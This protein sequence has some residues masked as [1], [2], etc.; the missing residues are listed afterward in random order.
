MTDNT[1]E[2]T[3]AE[4]QQQT[5]DRII[6]PFLGKRDPLIA[7]LQ[8]TQT[9]FG[10]VPREAIEEISNRLRIPAAQ[11][12]G[13][14]TFYAHF[15]LQRRGDHIVRVCQGTACH[16]R[17]A[18]NIMKTTEHHLGIKTGETTEDYGYTLER[19]ACLGSCALA[20]IMTVDD[21]MHVQITIKKVADIF[22]E[23]T[24]DDTTKQKNE[25]QET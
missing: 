1:V 20:P 19:V 2:K 4:E 10:Y 7:V 3:W 18:G 22:S 9:V 12:F 17:G 25:D 15:Y 8:E 16:I 24:H 14:A 5:M 11:I 21:D 23:Y 13:V 6:E